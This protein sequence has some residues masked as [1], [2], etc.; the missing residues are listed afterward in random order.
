MNLFFL[1][2]YSSLTRAT[3]HFFHCVH[4][5]LNDTGTSTSAL[6]YSAILLEVDVTL[7]EYR[8]ATHLMQAL[9]S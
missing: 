3:T 6:S 5:T 8:P 9:K 7:N 2:L 1:S 4:T